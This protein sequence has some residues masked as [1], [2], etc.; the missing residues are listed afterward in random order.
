MNLLRSSFSTKNSSRMPRTEG[1]R[2]GIYEVLSPLGA[3]GMGEMIRKEEPYRK[4]HVVLN[5]FSELE[6]LVPIP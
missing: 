3:G 1:S 5:W 2:L 4:I 6:R